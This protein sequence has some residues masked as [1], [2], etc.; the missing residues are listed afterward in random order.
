VAEFER[1]SI[2]EDFARAKSHPAIKRS[3][4]PIN[5]VRLIGGNAAISTGIGAS[6][7]RKAEPLARVYVCARQPILGRRDLELAKFFREG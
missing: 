1:A 2:A 6:K 4:C 7:C 3:F 5:T